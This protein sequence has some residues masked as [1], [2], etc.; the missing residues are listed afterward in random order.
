MARDD[1]FFMKTFHRRIDAEGPGFPWILDVN[2]VITD[3]RRDD[4]T[5]TIPVEGVFV[6]PTAYRAYF[7]RLGPI[8]S[9]TI[10]KD[11]PFSQG[12]A[13][14]TSEGLADE[15]PFPWMTKWGGVTTDSFCQPAVS[16]SCLSEA[17][18]IVASKIHNQEYDFGQTLGELPETIGF[19]ALT[20]SKLLRAY[21]AVRRGHY[22]YAASLL[23]LNPRGSKVQKAIKGSKT[24]AQVWLSLQFG[25]KPLL[26]DIYQLYHVTQTGLPKARLLVKVNHR[27]A[28]YEPPEIYSFN[29]KGSVK[30]TFV[31]G[32]EYGYSLGISNQGLLDLNNLGLANPLSIAWELLPMSFVLDW[33]LPIG[34][35]FQTLGSGIGLSIND[36]YRT[37]YLENHY[38]VRFMGNANWYHS[39]DLPGCTVSHTAMRRNVETVLPV[40]VPTLRWSLNYSQ[41]ISLFALARALVR[42]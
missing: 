20:S 13:T 29:T 35:F 36:G 27:D 9:T 34:G 31:R 22:R 37:L 28:L 15:E 4:G 41:I 39:G 11:V 21:L 32:V 3:S 19:L 8:A 25:W 33:F 1:F 5:S 17:A 38:E 40:A 6:K 2:S 23:G 26:N 14:M 24:A 30:G 16:Q 18:S 7:F 12:I 42:L 10:L